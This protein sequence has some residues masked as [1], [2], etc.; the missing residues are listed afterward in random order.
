M[1]ELGYLE[2]QNIKFE[3]RA[4]DGDFGR[5]PGLAAS[6]AQTRV[7]V[8]VAVAPGAIRA[9]RQ[10]VSISELTDLL[11]ADGVT[12]KGDTV[13][14]HCRA[15]HQSG[16]LARSGSGPTTRYTAAPIPDEAVIRDSA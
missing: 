11:K 6:L 2:G 12:L 14:K 16:L 8:I 3:D 5:L 13:S 1:R 15:L 4:D 10:P 7:D 9:A